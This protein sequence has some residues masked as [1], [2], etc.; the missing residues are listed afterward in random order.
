MQV[1]M[2]TAAPARCNTTGMPVMAAA[3]AIVAIGPGAQPALFASKGGVPGRSAG[4]PVVH[5]ACTSAGLMGISIGRRRE[6]GLH[7]DAQIEPDRPVVDVIEVV[8]H[9]L[10]HLVVGVGFTAK[11]MNL[12]PAGD[13]R[14]H[15]VA[16]GVK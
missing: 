3:S 13:A 1:A 10:S 12:R 8:L 14:L 15:V 7:Q 5:L 16:A 2:A 11:T 6:H 9:A 4:A